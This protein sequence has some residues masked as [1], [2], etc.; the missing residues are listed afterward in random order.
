MQCVEYLGIHGPDSIDLDSVLVGRRNRRAFHWF[1]D[2]IG[3]VVVGASR[4]EQMKY[5]RLPHEWLTP[6]LEAFGLLCLENCFE[7]IRSQVLGEDRIATSKWTADGRGAKRNQ[8]WHQ[9]GIRRYNSLLEQVRVDRLNFPREDD[10]YLSEK[11]EEKRLRENEKL[12]KRQEVITGRETGLLAA[13]DDFSSSSDD[14][15]N[16]SN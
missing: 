1:L 16:E 11:K 3:S 6:S 7:R 5:T 2:E 4:A 10:V 12:R 14:S 13:M 8:G 15:G 9:D